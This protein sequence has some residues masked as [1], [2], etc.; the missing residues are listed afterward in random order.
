MENECHLC[1]VLLP[2]SIA[3]V[4]VNRREINENIQSSELPRESLVQLRMLSSVLPLPHSALYLAD[5][6]K[7]LI[8]GNF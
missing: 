6:P 4:V 8:K 7:F 2:E 1:R 5:I 3:K